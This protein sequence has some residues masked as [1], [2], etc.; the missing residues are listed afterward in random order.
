MPREP[1]GYRL[2]LERLNERFPGVDMLTPKQCAE[3]IGCDVSTVYRKIKFNAQFHRIT[4]V[5]F[6]LWICA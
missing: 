6:A 1:E 5:E 2:I 4:K 3:F